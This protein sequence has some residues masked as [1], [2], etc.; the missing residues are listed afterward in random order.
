MAETLQDFPLFPLGLVLLPGEVVP[1][2]IFEERYQ[3]MIDECLDQGREFGIVWLA[4]DELKHVGCTAAITE[5]LERMDD[6]RMNILCRGSSPFRL[7]RRIDTLPYPAGDIELLDDA[8]EEPSDG[9]AEEA[10][11]RYADLVQRVTDERP[12]ERDVA[13]MGAYEMAGSIDFAPEAKQGLLEAR[14]EEERMQLITELFGTTM[15]RLDYVER[16][17][18]RARSNGRVRP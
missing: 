14:S 2:H 10:R 11:E 18:E 8:D 13:A 9:T 6:G 1:L 5:L 3:V 15:K 17:L 4:D 12:P 16:S 7:L